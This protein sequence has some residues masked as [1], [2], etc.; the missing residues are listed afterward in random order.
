MV[1]NPP[2]GIKKMK[3]GSWQLKI[4]KIIGHWLCRFRCSLTERYIQRLMKRQ[5]ISVVDSQGKPIQSRSQEN[6]LD[7]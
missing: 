7:Y 4:N 2:L 3:I 5:G 1:I 6:K